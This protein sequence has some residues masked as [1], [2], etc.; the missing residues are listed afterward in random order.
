MQ[1]HIVVTDNDPTVEIT[2][3]MRAS[4]AKM[5]GEEIDTNVLYADTR[6]EDLFVA[7][8]DALLAVETAVGRRG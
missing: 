6:C 2:L 1:H 3:T 7:L 8:F 5:L 4:E